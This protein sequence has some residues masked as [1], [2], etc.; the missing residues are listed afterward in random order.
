VDADIRQRAGFEV[1]DGL[2]LPEVKQTK[3]ELNF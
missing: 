1:A 3:N 2:P